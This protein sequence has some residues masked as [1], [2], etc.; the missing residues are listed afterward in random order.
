MKKST[1]NQYIIHERKGYDLILP[2]HSELSKI[3]TDCPVCG[4]CMRDF[5]DAI[6]YKSYECCT[7]CRETWVHMDQEGWK[8]GLRP[9]GDRF[10]A[11]IL[12]KSKRPSFYSL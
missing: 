8:K 3:P 11:Y 4:F 7:E 6:S 12:N 5:S 1:N 2:E 10:D 9:S